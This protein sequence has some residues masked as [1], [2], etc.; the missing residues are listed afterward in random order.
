MVFRDRISRNNGK[1]CVWFGNLE[2]LA[3]LYAD[4]VVLF[5]AKT[6]VVW[7]CVSSGIFASSAGVQVSG[8]LVHVEW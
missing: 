3:S 7:V 2:V 1:D 8:H 4:D 6:V 5:L